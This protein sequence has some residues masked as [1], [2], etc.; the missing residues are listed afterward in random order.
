MAD[1]NIQMKAKNGASWDALFPVTKVGLV[2]GLEERIAEIPGGSTNASDIH[3]A[4]VA[5]N[6][7]ATNVEDA[8]AE[9]YAKLAIARTYS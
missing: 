1:K 5:N 4:D 8:N 7:S 6:T 2:E 3:I 9:L